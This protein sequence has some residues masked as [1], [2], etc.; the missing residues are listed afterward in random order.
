M[1]L[2]LMILNLCFGS[3]IERNEIYIKQ[4]GPKK[5]AMAITA[6]VVVANLVIYSPI[7]YANLKQNE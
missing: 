6:F 5:M 4:T 1:I 2:L 7:I 3:E